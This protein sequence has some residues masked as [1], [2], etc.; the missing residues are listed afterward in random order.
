M[1]RQTLLRIGLATALAG[2]WLA[3]TPGHVS[4]KVAAQKAAPASAD[5]LPVAGLQAPVTVR[6]D[7]RGIPYIEAAN[8]HDL[9]FAQGFVTAS[10]R[11]W[12]MDLLRRNIR[13]ELAEL[14][15]KVAFEEDKRR[16]ILGYAKQSEE[17]AAKTSGV[18]RT[19]MQAYADGVNAFIASC[20]EAKLPTEFRILKYK[21][22]PWTIADSLAIS[23]LMME[24]LSTTW[25][26][27]VMR[28]ALS[29]LPAAQREELLLEYTDM[30]TPVVGTDRGKPKTP[31]AKAAQAT[32]VKVSQEIVRLAQLDETI[33]Q[34]ALERVGLHAEIGRA[35]V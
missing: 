2:A 14:V 34:Q 20:D 1:M 12:Q 25:Q 13:G 35:H 21:P 17:L 4:L 8:D 19:T 5:A 22:R 15:G 27:D 9:Y 16:R 30:D 23:F 7:V 32:P 31:S 26:T 33:R 29:D 18:T 28:A 10:D 3:A 24:S 11:L 6:R